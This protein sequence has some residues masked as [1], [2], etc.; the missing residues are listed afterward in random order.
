MY[1]IRKSH[2]M[3]AATVALTALVAAPAAA[4]CPQ[5][6]CYVDLDA[7]GGTVCPSDSVYPTIT[8]E[9][10]PPPASKPRNPDIAL[11][12]APRTCADGSSFRAVVVQVEVPAQC[13]G[14]AVWVEYQGDPEEWTVNIG[15]SITNNGFGGDAGSLPAGQNAEVEVLDELVRV[16]SAADNPSEVD[17]LL[18]QHLALRDGALRFVVQNQYLSWGQ[19]YTALE[20]PD[21]ER[22]FFLPSAPVAPENRTIWVGLNRSVATPSRNGCGARRALIHVQ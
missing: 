22:L 20:T 19:Q 14:V 8:G 6:L 18:T 2:L 7:G 12:A 1:P 9:T 21:L 4:Q 11:S 5:F 3:L 15:D 16:W 10:D 13:T 17:A